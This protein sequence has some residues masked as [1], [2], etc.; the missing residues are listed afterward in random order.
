ML[1]ELFGSLL[2]AVTLYLDLTEIVEEYS[3]M[4]RHLQEDCFMHTAIAWSDFYNYLKKRQYN[5]SRFRLQ[6]EHA[7]CTIRS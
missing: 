3:M 1:T 5:S 4:L 6:C 7:F 2:L